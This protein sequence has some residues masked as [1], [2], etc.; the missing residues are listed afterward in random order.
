MEN[1][2]LVQ[3]VMDQGL[4]PDPGWPSP[5]YERSSSFLSQ[6]PYQDQIHVMFFHN[7]NTDL[8]MTS[9]GLGQPPLRPQRLL[10]N[11]VPLCEIIEPLFTDD[12]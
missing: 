8:C 9:C 3:P 5:D 10:P 6:R 4:P 1:I 12:E 11:E 7:G 2:D